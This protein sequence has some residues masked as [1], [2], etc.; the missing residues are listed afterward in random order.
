[1]KDEFFENVSRILTR[2]VRP[3]LKI[4]HHGWTRKMFANM[5]VTTI[6]TKSAIIIL[7]EYWSQ[8]K[9]I[10]CSL[11]FTGFFLKAVFSWFHYSSFCDFGNILIPLC[12]PHCCLTVNEKRPNSSR[13]NFKPQPSQ[14]RHAF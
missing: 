1:M 4:A 10:S 3:E 14:T 5:N 7:L 12:R 13:E 11:R 2:K 6:F 9:F 8:T